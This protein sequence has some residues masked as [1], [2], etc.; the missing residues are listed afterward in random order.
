[1]ADSTIRIF[2]WCV[3]LAVEFAKESPLTSDIPLILVA[4]FLGCLFL[5]VT[6]WL[7]EQF[8]EALFRLVSYLRD[9]N[10]NIIMT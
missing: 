9:T 10:L 8:V 6:K 7:S 2:N 3:V 5:S 1:M 4:I